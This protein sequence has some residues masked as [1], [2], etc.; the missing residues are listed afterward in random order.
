[1]GGLGGPRTPEEYEYDRRRREARRKESQEGALGAAL[2]WIGTPLALLVGPQYIDNNPSVR[3]KLPKPVVEFSRTVQKN[4][5]SSWKDVEFKM[6]KFDSNNF[7]YSGTLKEKF[8]KTGS[9]TSGNKPK[10]APAPAPKPAAAAPK[11]QG[12]A[13]FSRH[14]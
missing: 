9:S 12:A 6:P 5:P 10:P 13:C 14:A 8:A 4:T 2:F 3:D 7:Q 1:M 11:R